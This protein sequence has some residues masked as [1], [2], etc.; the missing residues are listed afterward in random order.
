MWFRERDKHIRRRM[1]D[2]KSGIWERGR[3][4]AGGKTPGVSQTECMWE[5]HIAKDCDSEEL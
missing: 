4:R 1:R 5:R 2:F 3:Q